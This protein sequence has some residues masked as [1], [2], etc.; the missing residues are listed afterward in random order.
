MAEE[1]NQA[2][3]RRAQG[4]RRDCGIADETQVARL[5]AAAEA[6]AEIVIAG[7][8]RGFLEQRTIS[9][10]SKRNSRLSDSCGVDAG[11]PADHI[12][13]AVMARDM[14]GNAGGGGGEDAGDCLLEVRPHRRMLA[15][16]HRFGKS[17]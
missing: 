4:R 13:V 10:K 11:P 15:C 8:P 3:E 6:Q 12:D 16:F 17:L 9:G 14:V 7:L 1:L 5:E 2:L